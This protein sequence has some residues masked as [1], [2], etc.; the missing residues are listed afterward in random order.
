MRHI[1]FATCFAL[2]L[3][4]LACGTKKSKTDA[5][6][7]PAR[8]FAPDCTD[9]DEC[10][11]LTD[12]RDG[13]RSSRRDH[14]FPDLYFP[15]MGKGEY[16]P[17]P[18]DGSWGEF[19][20][21]DAFEP[22]FPEDDRSS[23]MVVRGFEAD[24]YSGGKLDESASCVAYVRA[25]HK[26]GFILETHSYGLQ[27][28]WIGLGDSVRC[29]IRLDLRMPKGYQFAIKQ[30]DT[31]VRSDLADGS[32]GKF[33]VEFGFDDREAS[34]SYERNYTGGRLYRDWNQLRVHPEQWQWS[35]CGGSTDFYLNYELYSNFKQLPKSDLEWEYA[36][37]RRE[38]FGSKHG[39]MQL[40]G[41]SSHSQIPLQIAWRKC[42][43]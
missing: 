29:E 19:D 40:G 3:S 18:R 15:D 31:V 4:P 24:L 32:R 2:S 14:R 36:L 12:P 30:V 7:P 20:D 22:E 10:P 42:S 1:M 41:L 38:K 25:H 23:R 26:Y 9:P 33:S 16:E 17:D 13:D 37:R 28:N 39:S 6:G 5:G 35:A 21:F 11:E 34:Y 43:R 27:P 8:D